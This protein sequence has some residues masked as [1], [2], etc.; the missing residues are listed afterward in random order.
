HLPEEVFTQA[1]EPPVSDGS[2]IIRDRQRR[3]YQLL[4]EAGYRVENDRM[5]NAEGQPL[6]FEFLVV[7]ANLERVIL[8]FKRNLAELGIELQLRRVDVSEYINRLRSRDFDTASGIWSHSI[9]PG[10]ERMEFWHSR[11]ANKARSRDFPGQR[12]P[13]IDPLVEGLRRAD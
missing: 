2:G 8:P 11:S 10:N 1:F 7:Q 9:S 12:D 4:L 5:V 6:S 13:A 3:A